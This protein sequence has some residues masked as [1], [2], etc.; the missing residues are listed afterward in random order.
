[1]RL[2][3]G[4]PVPGAEIL[5]RTAAGRWKLSATPK[6]GTD[7]VPRTYNAR[8]DE[9]TRQSYVAAPQLAFV[10]LGAVDRLSDDRR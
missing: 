8:L 3:D 5:T 2:A 9:P 10:T 1:V 6:A 7:L 4:T